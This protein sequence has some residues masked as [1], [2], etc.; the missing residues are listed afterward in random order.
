[1]VKIALS[2]KN[3]RSGMFG[4]GA[5]HLGTTVNT[6]TLPKKAVVEHGAMTTVWVL[7]KDHGA[8]MRI[9]KVGKITGDRIEILSGLSEGERVVVTGT[10]KVSE[11]AKVQE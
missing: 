1:M 11:G 6:I 3:L 4:R 9:I 8:R 2:Q 5:I 10:E 7:D